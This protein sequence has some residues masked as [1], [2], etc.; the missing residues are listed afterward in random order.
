[1]ASGAQPSSGFD[2]PVY[3]DATFAGLS[4]LIPVP[5]LDWLFEQF[6]RRRMAPAI[7]RRRGRPLASLVRDELNKADR[8]CLGALVALPLTGTLWLARRI[9][10]KLLYFF[11][12][13]DAADQLSYYWQ[14]AFLLD[15]MMERGHLDTP[16]SAQL[17]RL[18]MEQVLETTASPL[19]QLAQQVIVTPRHILRTLWKA[20]RG[21][22][23]EV[24]HQTQ[25][26]MTQ[27]WADVQGYFQSVAARYDQTYQLLAAN[28][29]ATT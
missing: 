13:K 12:V 15:Y 26:R 9:S 1:M 16:A 18:A 28:R 24:I 17:A 7:A 22:E 2:W 8:S 4:V 6:F 27:G 10:R 5:L 25:S 14:R 3:A 29:A 21:R 19:R 20:R 11:T 23:D